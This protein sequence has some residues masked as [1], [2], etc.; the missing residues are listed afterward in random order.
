M[1]VSKY[2]NHAGRTS[3][4]P[5]I[6]GDRTRQLFYREI[7]RTA[8]P[9]FEPAVP[10]TPSILKSL[11]ILRQHGMSPRDA[12]RLFCRPAQAAYFQICEE[13]QADDGW[14]SLYNAIQF[15]DLSS[16]SGQQLVSSASQTSPH[17][18]TGPFQHANGPRWSVLTGDTL[19]DSGII[20][21]DPSKAIDLYG[22]PPAMCYDQ[23][24]RGTESR[25]LDSQ[26]VPRSTPAFEAPSM[27]GFDFGF[28]LG[29]DEP[30]IPSVED[31]VTYEPQNAYHRHNG[32]S[33]S[34]AQ[35]SLSL[36]A[37]PSLNTAHLL[38]YS[39]TTTPS[40]RMT[41][42]SSIN[43][44]L[45]SSTKASLHEPAV[46]NK[47]FIGYTQP[48]PPK[49]CYRSPCPRCSKDFQSQKEFVSHMTAEHDRPIQ[50]LCL[51]LV[52]GES[53][54]C[55]FRTCRLA[56]F[57]KHHTEEHAKDCNM[58]GNGASSAP[59]C[60]GNEPNPNPKQVWGCWICKHPT[61]S[62][63]AWVNHHME[64][65]KGCTRQQLKWT[66]LIQSLL[67]QNATRLLWQNQLDQLEDSTG[68]IWNIKWSEATRNS[69]RETLVHNL[70]TGSFEGRSFDADASACQ[71]IV[72][73]A[74]D[75]TSNFKSMLEPIPST[76]K[77]SKRPSTSSPPR[78][79]HRKKS[80]ADSKHHPVIP[81]CTASQPASHS[82]FERAY[83]SR[84]K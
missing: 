60:Q 30:I 73:A 34:D 3:S 14:Q 4:Q 28:A 55:N 24:L 16:V 17:M 70:E 41:P 64:H 42:C 15:L 61:Y 79:L 19:R 65:H 57:K 13:L 26:F 52:P 46:P 58:P 68:Y 71:S 48:P 21:D 25:K 84:H 49:P 37:Q 67:A 69:V 62:V 80:F 50:Y 59:A 53:S 63:A 5:C 66:L 9:D 76:S 56:R 7:P 51:H 43:R 83:S 78:P 33:S 82:G 74:M 22:L 45:D 75:A 18:Y 6:D 2:N 32:F 36:P 20:V 54:Y 23:Q 47:D 40:Q 38:T 27:S 29:S 77:T 39:A 12:Q 81:S 35:M 72:M 1:S 11:A 10:E 31:S 44:D 8:I